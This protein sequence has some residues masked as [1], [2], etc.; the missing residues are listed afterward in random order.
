MV[1][2]KWTSLFYDKCIG[3]DDHSFNNEHT[4]QILIDDLDDNEYQYTTGDVAIAMFNKKFGSNGQSN[5]YLSTTIPELDKKL[6][7]VKMY[8]KVINFKNVYITIVNINNKTIYN[9]IKNKQ[10]IPQK[11]F[12]IDL[13]KYHIHYDK[14]SKQAEL[15]MGTKFNFTKEK[16]IQ[17]NIGNI[18][19]NVMTASKYNIEDAIDDPIDSEDS[20]D[21]LTAKLFDY[22]K[23]S[24]GWMVNKERHM[25]K[26]KIKYNINE[27]V[28]IGEVFFELTNQKFYSMDDRKELVFYGG[29]VIDEV[30]LGKTLQITTLSLLN[31]PKNISQVK[32]GSN[33]FHSR[34]TLVICP[35]T[36]CGQWKRELKSMIAKK[37]DPIIISMITKRELDKYTYE[38]LLDADFVI[39]SFT[40]LDNKNFTNKWVPELS[41]LKSYNKSSSFN[42]AKA[43]KVFDKMGKILVKD[44]L[45]NIQKKQP[46][47]HLIKWHR[48][49]VDEFHEVYGKK[50]PYVANL[51]PHIKSSFRWSVTA[52]PFINNNSLYNNVNYLT[53][54]ENP[55]EK[56]ILS[57]Y[58]VIKFLCNNCFRRNTKKS[59]EE[60]HTLPPIEE[61]IIW[62]KFT[63]TERMM[64]NAYL[65]NP[66][67]KEFSVFLRQLCCH[68]QLAEE[69]KLALSN[70]KSL[71]DVEKMMVAHYKSTAIIAKQKYVKTHIRINK[72][73]E[74]INKIIERTQKN[75]VINT[76]KKMGYFQDSDS[77]DE[78][79]AMMVAM[80]FNE[81]EDDE[82]D[83]DNEN[84]QNKIA[85][86][87]IVNIDNN[88]KEEYIESIINDTEDYENIINKVV[89]TLENVNTD[90][91]INIVKNKAKKYKEIDLITID[92]LKDILKK[93]RESKLLLQKELD[94]KLVTYN[95]Y[96]NVI[97]RIK[98]IKEKEV[99]NSDSEGSDAE[100]DSDSESDSDTD[101]DS[102][103]E[104]VCGICLDNIKENDIGVTICGHLYCYSCLKAWIVKKHACPYCRKGLAKNSVF[105][106]SYEKKKKHKSLEDKKKDELINE[107]GT[108]L[109]NLIFYLKKHDKHTII[110]SQWDSLLKRVGHVLKDNGIKNVF[111]RGN[112][113]QRDKAVREFNSDDKIKVIMLSSE[114]SA[115]GT[116]LTK[117]TQI[118]LVDPV[119]GE[120]SYRKD[121]E[122]QAIGRAHRLG[123]K[124]KLKVVRFIIKDSV[125]QKIYNMNNEE[126]KQHADKRKVVEISVDD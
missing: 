123:Q 68:P 27:E 17:D 43:E 45:N 108:K 110:F 50:Y 42:H 18:V 2:S 99:N 73:I 33:K 118:V 46:L 71:N 74:N 36:L 87:I 15:L 53:N 32:S 79:D 34:A 31:Q 97:N 1:K 116:N 47:L 61:E 55:Y 12:L 106:L 102:D 115:S 90:K 6:Y 44:P 101:S 49:V 24:I 77:E 59:V 78:M 41:A 62:L 14:Q 100:V 23:C 70:C 91:L 72:V 20:F 10:E 11:K 69:T 63:H 96:N 64:Y 80:N 92:N 52:T 54:F 5:A 13:C 76:L 58:D 89:N 19:K 8:T 98:V 40:F 60:E 3:K 16:Q 51:L 81:N 48:L 114:S 7:Q 95:F 67:N 66:N 122:N 113:F 120:Y 112:V 105:M 25:K 94:G 85:E 30:G 111:C 93:T 39:T 26:N 38:D 103:D 37:Y 125:E 22:Q 82:D 56:R 83:E 28:Q 84:G 124:E 117:A 119:Y 121:T 109:A 88:Y 4:R 35:N 86:T 21:L 29:G 65:A 107:V 9:I 126:D 75:K 104:D 57:S